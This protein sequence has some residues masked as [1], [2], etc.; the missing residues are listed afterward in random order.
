MENFADALYQSPVFGTGL[1]YDS[2]YL[3]LF[4]D[5]NQP[6]PIE[7][8]SS[9]N[10]NYNSYICG[11]PGSG[12]STVLAIL[13]LALLAKP[14]NNPKLRG[15]LPVLMDVD[16]GKTSFGTK[17]LLKHMAGKEKEH[18]FLVHEMG[19]GVDSAINPHDLPMGRYEPTSRHKEI[20]VRFLM[21][22]IGGVHEDKASGM[23]KF[24]EPEL[25]G[26]ISSLVTSVYSMCKED[27]KPK[28]FHPAEFRHKSTI[29]FLKSIGIEPNKNYSYYGLAD[30]VMEKSPK[31]GADHALLLR[32]YAVP[33]LADYSPLIIDNPQIADKFKEGSMGG[34]SPITFFLDKL[35]QALNEYPCFSRPTVISID[36]ARMI[37]ID[38]DAVCGES[39]NRKAIF[40]SLMLMMFF[41]K[42]E[43]IEESKD[44]LDGVKPQH[45]PYLK[46]MDLINR[47]LPGTLNIEEAHMLFSLFDSLLI[48]AQRRNRKRG[49]G[50]RSLSQGLMDPSDK[51]FSMTSSVYIATEET[52]KKVDERL[53]SIQASNA[54][55]RIVNKGLPG[56]NI[57]LY[58]RTKGDDG[59]DVKAAVSRVGVRLN[60]KISPGLL[61]FSNSE[62]VD[63]G[64]RDDVFEKIGYEEGL[65]RLSLFFK[66]GSVRKLFES[67]SLKRIAKKRGFD[68]V[69]SLLLDA[70]SKGDKPDP[71]L[72]SEL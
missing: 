14:K 6:Y 28:M 66:S 69:Y 12:K 61:W 35:S 4:T 44:L 17:K 26:M 2:G 32:R 9:K 16:F 22:L 70:I 52:G 21:A 56:R 71:E 30:L 3:H 64:F 43:N 13:N 7:E 62:Q 60:T 31:K 53:N 5:D 47:V 23:F 41:S 33:R 39:D 34:K 49:W 48:T 57:F 51:L 42:R 27:Y 15:E 10:M 72:A 46:R 37:S 40:G 59:D 11:T 54:E 45:L 20:L 29:E 65:V 63:I 19:T 38:I 50:I 24:N 55:K 67:Q 25:E 8:H 58:I 36:K 68:S 18:L 1:I